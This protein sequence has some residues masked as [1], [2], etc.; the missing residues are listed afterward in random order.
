LRDFEVEKRQGCALLRIKCC[1]VC[2][3]AWE[4]HAVGCEQ[5]W[6][7][8]REWGW[9]WTWALKTMDL[10]CPCVD[11]VCGYWCWWTVSRILTTSDQIQV[12]WGRSSTIG[13]IL[14]WQLE[15]T[16]ECCIVLLLFIRSAGWRGLMEEVELDIKRLARRNLGRDDRW[17]AYYRV[18]N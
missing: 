3:P 18:Y 8:A 15:L 5:D 16:I 12:S 11:F 6:Q 10:L 17:M 1:F 4:V 2:K 13:S 7:W 9:C 14:L